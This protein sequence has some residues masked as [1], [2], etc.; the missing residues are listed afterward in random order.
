[1]IGRLRDRIHVGPL[2]FF[3]IIYYQAS[4]Y[5]LSS[6]IDR[7][8]IIQLIYFLKSSNK[9]CV[10]TESRSGFPHE[11][12]KYAPL[13]ISFFMFSYCIS[14]ITCAWETN[15]YFQVRNLEMSPVQRT[16]K[17][18][19][20]QKFFRVQLHTEHTAKVYVCVTFFQISIIDNQ[21]SFSCLII[22]K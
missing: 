17:D 13:Q 16:N 5:F 2:K 14:L 18:F 6:C 7:I 4:F 10:L 8:I 3:Q 20:V 12:V 11:M 15:M 9:C 19:S 1:V 22:T 21:V